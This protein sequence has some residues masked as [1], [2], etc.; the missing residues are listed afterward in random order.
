MNDC[1]R[2]LM[3]AVWWGHYKGA[4]SMAPAM[5]LR[6][7]SCMWPVQRFRIDIRAPAGKTRFSLPTSNNREM[8]AKQVRADTLITLK[9]APH[10]L[11]QPSLSSP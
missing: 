9:H 2:A 3:H 7:S 11:G 10:H 1:Q 8:A 6:P 4:G 5:T